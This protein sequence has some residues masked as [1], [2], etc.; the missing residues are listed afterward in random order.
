MIS[1]T[2]VDYDQIQN[3]GDMYGRRGIRYPSPFFDLAR[4]YIPDNVKEM[5]KWCRYFYYKHPLVN[6]TI[7]KLSEFPITDL[8]YESPS[9]TLNKWWEDT[10]ERYMK[11]RS[12]A[13]RI[14]T[15]YNALG[16]AFISINVP[17]SKR[18]T[19]KK[20]G[21]SHNIERITYKWINFR[22]KAKCQACGRDDFMEVRDVYIKDR[23]RFNFVVW[24]PLDIEIDYNDITGK[25]RYYYV[26]SAKLKSAIYQGRRHIID[27]L[28]QIF[29]EA[30]KRKK[31]I[32]LP[33]HN[34]YH[35]KRDGL[36]EKDQEWGK[37]LIYPVMTTI[38]YMQVLYRAQEAIANQHIVPLWVLYPQATPTMDPYSF[39]NMDNWKSQIEEEV[40]M[41]KKDPNHIP[42]LPMPIGFS[43]VGG[44][45]RGLLLG[46]EIQQNS[47]V[48]MA[49]MGVPQEFI[50]GGL[51][52]TGTSVTLRMLENQLLGHIRSIRTF[53][54][55]FVIPFL[56]KYL[57]QA[58]IS[59]RMSDFKM[60]DDIQR[61]QIMISLNSSEK[62]SDKK[63]LE[64][65]DPKLDI[66][67]ETKVRMK[68]LED[69]MSYSSIQ[70]LRVAS[71]QGNAAV[72]S[73]GYQAETA[74]LQ[75]KAQTKAQF[76]AQE[77]QTAHMLQLEQRA[78]AGDP[79]A[80]KM[81][82]QMQ[83]QPQVDENGN[84]VQQGP[85]QQGQ[86]QG[87]QQGAVPAIDPS[88]IAQLAQMPPE[89]LQ[90][91]L[92]SGQID[93]NTAQVVQMVQQAMQLDPQQLEE[94]VNQGQLPPDVVPLLEAVNRVGSQGP[95]AGNNMNINMTVEQDI[96]GVDINQALERTV[97]GLKGTK[98]GMMAASYARQFMLLPPEVYKI[99]AQKMYEET[100]NLYNIVNLVYNDLMQ[101]RGQGN[102]QNTQSKVVSNQPQGKGSQKAG[103]SASTNKKG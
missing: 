36:A 72:V 43:T 92:N 98:V 85:G 54:E 31:R 42:V 10:L 19:C 8:I 5:F 25:S 91:A 20:C 24:D 23:T 67:E 48:V 38:Y 13:I 84:P 79:I 83:Q 63:L 6:P 101:G 55:D 17:I 90:E 78:Q 29:I 100:P 16:N 45:G 96:T 2:G 37:P 1:A 77:E 22:C 80:Q 51:S 70:S 87:Q 15:N 82:E 18:L 35:F 11:F 97:P 47:Q 52:Y 27:T 86:P 41:W 59:I 76:A 53:L 50:F 30:V 14:G 57:G 71:I 102:E 68:E 21:K 95:G 33:E 46:P 66:K 64:M 93:Q 62:I 65:V 4:T 60:A 12:T 40:A 44:E 34:F 32:E 56:S 99:V 61:K 9:S 88:M 69:K 73:A 89:Q 74:V 103:G 28:P 58:P 75:A 3:Y 81:I 94:A 39:L 7:N 26:P 49:G